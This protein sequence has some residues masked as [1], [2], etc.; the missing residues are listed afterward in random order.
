M[1]PAKRPPF[2]KGTRKACSGP[3]AK[4]FLVLGCHREQEPIVVY[5]S[6]D[7][8]VARPIL[9]QFTSMT[10]RPVLMVGDTEATK[11]TGLVERI[12][13]NATIRSP[14]CSGPPRPS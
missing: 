4:T 12:G 2:R 14:M 5:V 9:D 6:A 11:T 7:E 13:V 8:Y 1:N 3:S 10:G